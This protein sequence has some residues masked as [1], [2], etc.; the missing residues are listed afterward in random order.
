MAN[1]YELTALAADCKGITAFTLTGSMKETAEWHKLTSGIKITPTYTLET[2]VDDAVTNMVTSGTGAVYANPVPQFRSRDVGKITYTAGSGDDALA[3]IKSIT[4][5]GKNGTTVYDG[6]NALSGAWAAA[7]NDTTNGVITFAAA[8]IS[9][10]ARD[11][12]SD[13]T[14]EATVTY[15]TSGGVERTATV[16]LILR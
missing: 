15:E 16:E 5:V 11:F 8:Y 7:D 4:M 12:P 14:K 3:T 9:G 13:T 1:I 10:F 6:F 2:V